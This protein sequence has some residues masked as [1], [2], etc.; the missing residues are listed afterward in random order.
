MKD[1]KIFT[2]N[3][4]EKALDQINKLMDQ[5]AF[6]DAKVR[7]MPDVHAGSGCTIGFTAD[8]G[9]KVIP[10][11]VGVDIGCGMYVTKLDKDTDLDLEKLDQVIHE[12]VPSGLNVHDTDQI[13]IDVLKELR[14]FSELKKTNWLLKSLYSLGS[15][16]HFIEVDIDDEGYKYLVIHTGSRNLGKQVCDHYQNKAIEIHSKKNRYN[17][18][19]KEIVERCNKENRRS[20]IQKEIKAFKEEF[21]NRVPDM[22]SDLCYS[23]GQDRDDY[24]FDMKICQG[25]AK[26]NRKGIAKII[27]DHMDIK[28]DKIIETFDTIHNY[29]SFE[30]NIVRKGAISARL[31]EKLI[32]PINMRDGCIIGI[33]KGND[34]WNNSAPHG[35]GRIMTRMKA[36]NTL[37]LEDYK[38]SMEGIYTSSVSLDTI[39]EVPMVYKP[40]QEIIDNIKDTVDIIKI[41]KPI[42]NFK[43]SDKER[44]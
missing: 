39:D 10:N 33:G 37:K 16:N 4:D 43:A 36:F 12:Y 30:D 42:Y 8:L 15:G 40:M 28:E 23:E 6:C 7:I 34:D 17:E 2:T 1:L 27:L 44:S 26:E 38:D 11:V 9:D 14:C 19:V 24:L 22:P 20:D 25:F 13:S 41:I 3:I 32:I 29:I 5:P 18:E 31:N 21:E 35:A